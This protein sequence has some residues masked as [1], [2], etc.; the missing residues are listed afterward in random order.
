MALLPRVG[1]CKFP[2]LPFGI[3]DLS[4]WIAD[5]LF[6]YDGLE[7]QAV[8]LREQKQDFTIFWM[9]TTWLVLGVP[10]DDM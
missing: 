6:W 10:R 4:H 8:Y 2:A 7:K 1:F 3:G 9:A 5:G